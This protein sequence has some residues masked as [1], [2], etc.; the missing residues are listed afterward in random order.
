M[1]T[2]SSPRSKFSWIRGSLHR[3][4]QQS[5]SGEA[6]V[7]VDIFDL[8]G[9][10]GNGNEYLLERDATIPLSSSNWSPTELNIDFTQSVFIAMNGGITIDCAPSF[11]IANPLRSHSPSRRTPCNETNT[12][13]DNG[14][15]DFW[16]SC[17]CFEGFGGPDCACEDATTCNGNGT[18]TAAGNCVC[19]A[20]FGGPD[21]TCDDAINCNGNGVCDASG[22]CVCTDPAWEGPACDEPTCIPERDCSSNGT[23]EAGECICNAGFIGDDCA[24]QL[25]DPAV[26][27]DGV[28]VAVGT[29]QPQVVATDA[30]GSLLTWSNR[31]FTLF[32]QPSPINLGLATGLNPMSV[33]AGE[34]LVIINSPGT[35]PASGIFDA[36]YRS[37]TPG[38]LDLTLQGNYVCPG[39]PFECYPV[40][41]RSA[42][43]RTGAA[44][45]S[46]R[47]RRFRG[48]LVGSGPGEL[49]T[50]LNGAPI[51]YSVDGAALCLTS[52]SQ[53]SCDGTAYLNA[54]KGVATE[55]V[56]PSPVSIR[57]V[58]AD[59]S[60]PT[61]QTLLPIKL[62]LI[63]DNVLTAGYTTAVSS[64]QEAGTISSDFSLEA[65]GFG[66]VFVDITTT[67][68][69]EDDVTVCF[70]Y[71]ETMVDECDLRLLHN[72][73]GG[74]DEFVDVTLG[75]AHEDCPFDDAETDCANNLCIN[76]VTNQ[77]CGGATSL[78]PW[79]PAIFVGNNAPVVDAGP[80]QAVT[81]IGTVVQLDGSA[82]YDLDGDPLSYSW[83]L[84]GPPGSAAALQGATTPMPSF[85]PDV[86]GD[87]IA[88]LVVTDSGGLSGTDE[89]LV[90][91][92]NVPPVADA[93]AY[94]PAVRV[95]EM[96][97]LDGSASTDAN[98]DSLGYQ[99]SIVLAPAGSVAMLD[100]ITAAMPT[101]TPDVAGTYQIDLIVSDG[102]AESDVASVTIVATTAEGELVEALEAAIDAVTG[103][104]P[105]VFKNKSLQKNM[106]KHIAQALAHVDNGKL[107]AAR[108]KLEAV[109]QKTD[110]CA[111]ASS[112][113]PNDWITD[114]A[115]QSQVHPLIAEAI[116]LI[117]EILGQ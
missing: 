51:T 59:P 94:P 61:G 72:A 76:T 86:Y 113:D 85:A 42:C 90:S 104:D 78:S 96:V 117:D 75:E 70:E 109:L 20:G 45:S 84:S 98:G 79:T 54:F 4:A 48:T 50:E 7:I 15:C 87:F 101:F 68:Q 97:L 60:D 74:A 66:P 1:K 92:D 38:V 53:I 110:G 3:R 63:Y 115:A 116:A 108:E 30:S 43:I 41:R 34:G 37:N 9:I 17:D 12:C 58:F 91:F 16:G 69:F 49:P 88:T 99:W 2:R 56:S 27:C 11:A 64:S 10:P 67:A 46:P 40:L 29:I 32:D 6:N 28:P 18:C 73:D 5:I 111:T 80:D 39:T 24:T 93:T 21:C 106:A 31:E 82:S 95:G 89:V 102:I 65:L 71:P 23:C 112:P 52:G 100:D 57:Q 47:W 81:V 33:H 8:D 55:V 22:A 62:D 36:I 35:S 14:T 105:T 107:N 103:L 44:T 114:C 26:D 77:V 25:C 19:D 83:T 13:N